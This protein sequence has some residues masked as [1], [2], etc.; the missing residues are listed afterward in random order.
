MKEIKPEVW[1]FGGHIQICIVEGLNSADI[2][3]VTIIKVSLDLKVK[4][5]L[6]NLGI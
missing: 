5:Y 1:C 3:P 4:V 2:L 6:R